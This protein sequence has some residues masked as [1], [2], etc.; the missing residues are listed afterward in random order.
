MA[1]VPVDVT[2]EPVAHDADDAT[3]VENLRLQ[4]AGAGEEEL[5]LGR[6]GH[7]GSERLGQEGRE[8][9]DDDAADKSTGHR[10]DTSD[11]DGGQNEQ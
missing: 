6:V 10:A 8:P 2:L 3:R 11:H 4:Q 9:E 1:R 5:E 7:D